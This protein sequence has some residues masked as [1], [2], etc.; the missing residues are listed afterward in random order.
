MPENEDDLQR[1]SPDG[2]MTMFSRSHIAL[3]LVIAIGLHVAVIASTSM[4]YI[5]DRWI[6]PEGAALRRIARQRE[7]EKRRAAQ[8]A[9]R[10]GTA[11]QASATRPATTA[12][13]AASPARRAEQAVP[14]RARNS[15]MYK[16]TTQKAA[17]GEIPKLPEELTVPLE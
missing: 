12:K 14:P 5:R 3:C 1:L 11:T 13:A 9:A 8:R 10:R 4:P 7:L 2:L 15:R 16:A 17:P 6:D